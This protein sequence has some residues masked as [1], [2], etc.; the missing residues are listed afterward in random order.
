MI[1]NAFKKLICIKCQY[2]DAADDCLH[3][4]KCLQYELVKMVSESTVEILKPTFFSKNLL[5][6]SN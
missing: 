1:S 4:Q 6:D 2:F 3:C 5:K